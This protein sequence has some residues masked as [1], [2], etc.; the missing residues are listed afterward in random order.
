ME[1]ITEEIQQLESGKLNSHKTPGEEK[2]SR[3]VLESFVEQVAHAL[4]DDHRIAFKQPLK[5]KHAKIKYK[6]DRLA[7]RSRRHVFASA[8]VFLMFTI[9]I[10][11]LSK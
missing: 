8:S 9:F 11:I 3:Y 2:A 1:S 4:Q 5:E 6:V 7:L 10:G